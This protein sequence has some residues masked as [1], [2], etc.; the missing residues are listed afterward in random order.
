MS[1]PIRLTDV[2]RRSVQ[3]TVQY[4]STM[5]ELAVDCLQTLL[6]TLTQSTT[7]DPKTLTGPSVENSAS[8]SNSAPISM[9]LEAEAGRQALGVFLVENDF[10]RAVSAVPSASVVVD[11][12]GNELKPTIEFQPS[13]IT[14]QP[15]EQIV[16][17]VL[18]TI[19]EDMSPGVRYRGEIGVPGLMGTRIPVVMGRTINAKPAPQKVRLTSSEAGP[20]RKNRRRNSSSNGKARSKG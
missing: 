11:D 14:L 8:T 18:A 16:V 12:E 4:Y 1:E 6:G 17:K 9:V 15:R 10:S 5:G 2:W 3:A 7:N 20:H 13:S 19:S